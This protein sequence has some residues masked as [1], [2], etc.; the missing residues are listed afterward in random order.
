MSA[1]IW[2]DV[3]VAIQ[4]SIGADVTITGITKASPAV[5][6]TAT[7]PNNDDYVRIVCQ[8]MTEV[9]N[10]IFRVA[11]VVLD[12]SFELKDE[13]STNYDTFTSGSH[14][15]TTFGTSLGTIRNVTGSG[16]EYNFVDTTTIHDKISTQVPGTATALTYA[17]ENRWEPDDSGLIAL[18]AASIIKA[19]RAV[20]MTFADGAITVFYGYVGCTLVPTGSA[21]DLVSTPVTFTASGLPTNYTS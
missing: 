14:A 7:T 18:R 8:G 9:N 2:S 10:R 19:E 13:D 6:S 16:G 15:T 4:S 5:V 11:N 3:S 21:Q 1:R 17:M 20:K 12:T